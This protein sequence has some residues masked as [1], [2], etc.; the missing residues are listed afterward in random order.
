[1]PK[2]GGIKRGGSLRK[3]DEKEQRTKAKVK[4]KNKNKGKSK[5]A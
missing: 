4:N 1:L 3:A 2:R 5:G